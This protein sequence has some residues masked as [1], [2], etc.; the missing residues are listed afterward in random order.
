M[1]PVTRTSPLGS[2]GPS[3]PAV[4]VH[5]APTVLGA[6]SGHASD[7]L[8]G[9]DVLRD[10]IADIRRPL[11]VLGSAGGDS[12]GASPT[13]ASRG[14]ARFGT[15]LRLRDGDRAIVGHVAPLRLDSLGD[16][17]FRRAHGL[18][19]GC[20]AG[21]MAN[22]I[23]SVEMVEAMSHAGMLGIFGAAGL[24]TRTIE[25]A[26]DRLTSSLGGGAFG[27]NLIHS[28]NE[29]ELEQAVVDLYLRHGV[30]LVEASAYMRL[31][32]PLIRYRVSG[33]YRDTDGRVVTPNRVIAKASRVEVATR[34]FSPPPEPF[35]QELVAS[36]DITEKQAR[37]AR[38]IPVAQDL[39]AEADS[40]GHTDNRPALGLLP[41]MIALRD[42]LQ[43]EYGYSDALRVGAA[44]GI[45]TPHA[46]AAAFAMGAAYVVT[47]SVNQSCVEADTS[48]AVR[49]M[50]ANT[51]Q[52]D[53]AMA[54]AADMF[55]MG[56][57]VQVLKRGT[58]FAMRAGRL[59]ELY[60]A[61][62]SLEDIPADESK[63]L[64][65]TVFQASFG[66]VLDEV[67]TYFLERDPAQWERAQTDAK[68]RMALAFRWYLGRASHWANSGE[69]TRRLD[70]QIWCGPAMGAFNAWVQDSFLAEPGNRSVVTVGLNLLYGAA[71]LNR[72]Q[73]L[74][75]QG[76]V[77]SPEQQQVLP[78]TLPQLELHLP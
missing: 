36:G 10:T 15:D 21:A 43:R 75:S 71:V 64:E 70:Y 55:E 51:E 72:I 9:E 20:V 54:P 50:L 12:V 74:R 61:Y 68:H 1:S 19:L 4:T 25:A 31:T 37:L 49:E 44:G 23:A 46:S 3:A 73:T 42:R 57:K 78:R 60:R 13:I 34:F 32:L 58:M 17:E 48:Q 41:A 56:V 30:R 29:P 26:I 77:L 63:K 66:E 45:A 39:T 47:G 33:I 8:S 7:V 52:A 18:K 2:G 53:I 14:E 62:D 38:E 35:L 27:F 6:W 24:P 59:Y 11:Y 5:P 16:P 67:R 65:Q 28:P 76:V 69:P 22:G 40:G